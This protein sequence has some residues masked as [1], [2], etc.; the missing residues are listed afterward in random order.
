MYIGNAGLSW[1]SGLVIGLLSMLYIF[2]YH[3]RI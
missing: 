1:L 3:N 2:I